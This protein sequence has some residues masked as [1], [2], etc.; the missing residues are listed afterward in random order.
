MSEPFTHVVSAS[1]PPLKTVLGVHPLR[2]QK[3]V[4]RRVQ[5][6]DCKEV[7]QEQYAQL[8]LQLR[9]FGQTGVRS[10]VV[11]QGEG[12]DYSSCLVEPFDFVVL[13]YFMSAHIALIWVWHLTQRWAKNC[14][15]S[16]G[17]FEV[18]QPQFCKGR[19][20]DMC[21]FHHNRN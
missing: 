6:P 11:M 15:D 19:T 10:G 7:E 16:E 2:Y 5:N 3:D 1:R 9:T 20:H 18:K 4:S 14:V 21:K 12:F 8:L 17:D 13:T